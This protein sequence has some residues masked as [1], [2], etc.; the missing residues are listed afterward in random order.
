MGLAT[1]RSLE[2]GVHVAVRD[3]MRFDRSKLV[4]GTRIPTRPSVGLAHTSPA[5]DVLD[6]DV[7]HVKAVYG[8]TVI[9]LWRYHTREVAYRAAIRLIRTVAHSYPEGVG[10][11]QVVETQ[12]IPPTDETRQA[13]K[14]AYELKGVHHFSVTYEGTGF[15]AAA[16]R[17]IVWSA[18]MLARPKFAHAVHKSVAEAA[19]WV[20]A[21]NRLIAHHDDWRQ[22]DRI[23]DQMRRL[24]RERYPGPLPQD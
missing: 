14:E 13:F 12:A 7:D 15:K 5:F 17:A 10:V 4:S 1:A 24:Q 20:E 2:Q 21:Q 3:D 23:V 11:M 16:V 8:N 6:L 18:H 22:L 19:R 9:L